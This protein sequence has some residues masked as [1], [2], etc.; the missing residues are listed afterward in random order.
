MDNAIKIEI[1]V[2][3]I[4][5]LG[6]ADIQYDSLSDDLKSKIYRDFATQ[7]VDD[8]I[9][10]DHFAEAVDETINGKISDIVDTVNDNLDYDHIVSEVSDAM[11]STIYDTV[12]NLINDFHV[13]STCGLAQ[14]AVQAITDTIRWDLLT[15][16]K[17]DVSHTAQ[18]FRVTVEDSSIVDEL[19]KFVNNLIDERMNTNITNK[20]SLNFEQIE[21]V[22]I[23]IGLDDAIRNKMREAFTAAVIAKS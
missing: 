9:V 22:M 3:E 5:K 11:N 6:L 14:T 2:S 15:Y 18:N 12:D 10:V 1:P 4:Q 21:T 17:S 16:N 23:S 19:K 13:N 8:N 20:A 7:I